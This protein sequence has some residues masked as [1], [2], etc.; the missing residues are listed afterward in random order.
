MPPRPPQ[1]LCCPI[2]E[3]LYEDPVLLIESGQTYDRKSI[4]KWLQQRNTCPLTGKEL[5]SQQLVP[6]FAVKGLVDAWRQAHMPI[7]APTAEN[8]ATKQYPEIFSGSPQDRAGQLSAA[9]SHIRSPSM[10]VSP[11]NSLQIA[12]GAGPHPLPCI[13]LEWTNCIP[14]KCL[15]AD[16]AVSPGP[17]A[18]HAACILQIWEDISALAAASPYWG[19]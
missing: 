15:I 8:G 4:E 6:N 16:S 5:T 11:L 13:I 19:E 12:R 10:K 1:E 3:D 18:M 17:F 9:L 2:S 14:V 7:T